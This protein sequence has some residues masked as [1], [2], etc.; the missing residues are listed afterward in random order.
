LEFAVNSYF[1]KVFCVRSQTVVDECQA[2]FNCP[3]ISETI[4]IR[5]LK[6]LHKYITYL[7]SELCKVFNDKATAEMRA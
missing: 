7:D 4:T 2:P 1:R 3:P 5:T 6:F